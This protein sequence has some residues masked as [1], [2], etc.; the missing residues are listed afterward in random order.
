MNIDEQYELLT[1]E[2]KAWFDEK[3]A[4]MAPTIEKLKEESKWLQN[5]AKV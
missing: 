1:P 3:V 4:T 2:Q 5:K